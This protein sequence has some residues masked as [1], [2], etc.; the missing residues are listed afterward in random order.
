MIRGFLA[1]MPVGDGVRVGPGDDCAVIDGDIALTSDMSIEGVHFRRD[2]LS[3]QEIGYRCAAIALSDL[4][5]VAARPIGVLVSLGCTDAD[6]PEPAELL[7]E[8]IREA[9]R[10]CGAS[11]L[12][13]DLTRSPKSLVVDVT[14]VGHARAPV[15]RSGAREGDS[16]WVSGRLGA[17]AAA[18]RMLQRGRIPGDDA[19]TAFAHPLPRI[20][21]ALWLAERGVLHSLIDLSDGLLGDAGHIA[22][23]SGVALL[24]EESEVPKHPAALRVRGNRAQIELALS[25]GDDYELCFT[26]PP[27]AVEKELAEFEHKFELPLT[28]VGLVQ[29]G[30]G[31]KLR[32]E[33][34]IVD[35]VLAGG[36][37]HFEENP[38]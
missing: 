20:A 16:L 31:V 8:G 22:A 25:G 12:G 23:A 5:A 24:I 26:S 35:E 33:S 6:V 15:L 32:H 10:A 21:E 36:Y 3:A 9:L 19:R 7:M 27:G 28:R 38:R 18:V 1:R 2:W 37:Q 30:S 29:E 11:L 14:A 13:G 4:A 34:G 17:A